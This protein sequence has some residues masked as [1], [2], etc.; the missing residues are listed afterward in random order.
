MRLQTRV[1]ELAQAQGYTSDR[2]LAKAMGVSPALVSRVRSGQIGINNTFITG[3]RR[4]FPDKGLDQ[5]FSVDNDTSDAP[6][7]LIEEVA[8]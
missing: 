4:A 2:A 5:L 7:A 8:V 3:A 1:F 6:V